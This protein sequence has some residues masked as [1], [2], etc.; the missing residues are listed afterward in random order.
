M[1]NI[2]KKHLLISLIALLVGVFN[3]AFAQNEPPDEEPPEPETP[4]DGGI[5]L[6]LAAGAAYGAKKIHDFRKEEKKE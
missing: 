2:F 4:I 3:T 5:S 1:F 6:L